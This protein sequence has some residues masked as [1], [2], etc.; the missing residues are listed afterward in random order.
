LLAELPELARVITPEHVALA[1]L[2][3]DRRLEK[4]DR[5]SRFQRIPDVTVTTAPAP[6]E[7]TAPGVRIVRR[8]EDGSEETLATLKIPREALDILAW[9]SER[10]AA[11]GADEL[12]AAFPDIPFEGLK[13]LLASC[14]KGGLLRLLWFPAI[15]RS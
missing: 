9:L 4:I 10:E 8:P 13:K 11:F 1:M 7:G 5:A 3:E 15:A 12:A 2:P 6:G 14:A